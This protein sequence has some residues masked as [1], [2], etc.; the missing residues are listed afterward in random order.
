MVAKAPDAADP[1]TAY[2]MF[3]VAAG[4]D[5]GADDAFPLESVVTGFEPHVGM[6]FVAAGHPVSKGKLRPSTG[7]LRAGLA[8]V[9][10]EAVPLSDYP[11]HR[12]DARVHLAMQ[13]SPNDV[14]LAD[15]SPGTGPTPAGMSG[16]VLLLM[17][18]DSAGAVQLRPAGVLTAFRHGPP[19][20]LV[21]SRMESVLDH[22]A[23]RRPPELRDFARAV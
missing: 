21:A 8:F 5:P 20:I 14:R 3:E 10:G 16:G 23:P 18:Q 4:S 7:T 15:G 6:A 13:Y 2:A 11:K 22:L 9:V 12:L 1:D 17:T 19:S